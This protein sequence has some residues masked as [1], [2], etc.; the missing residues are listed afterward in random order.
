M[1]EK[2]NQLDKIDL[3]IL[4]VLSSEGR[5]SYRELSE[6]VN[7]SPRPCQTRVERLEAMGVIEGYRAVVKIPAPRKTIVIAQI[8]LTDHGRSQGPFEEEMRS[9]PAVL[10]CWLVSGAFDFPGAAGLRGPGRLPAPGRRLGCKARTSDLRRS[11][12]RLSC[13]PSSAAWS[14]G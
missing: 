4:E 2:R 7:L 9:N 11:S 6:R 3:R 5:I 1:A 14:E 8:A 13:R 12:R 10:D